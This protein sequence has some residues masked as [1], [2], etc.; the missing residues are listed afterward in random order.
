MFR[1][2]FIWFARSSTAWSR[3][4]W[5]G[6]DRSGLSPRELVERERS[7]VAPLLHLGELVLERF[8]VHD[9]GAVLAGPLPRR[10]VGVLVVVPESLAVLGLRLRPEVAAAGLAPV[11]RVDAHQLAELEEV[12]DPAGPLQGLVHAV[13]AAEDLD[14]APEVLAERPDQVDGLAQAVSG[15]LHAAVLP[16]DV[17]ELAV[18]GVDAAGAVGAKELL[19]LLRDR[20]L[21]LDHGR[22]VLGHLVER[23]LGQ[24]V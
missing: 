21:R 16:H 12:G 11:E 4:W 22:V 1:V 19:D 20:L 6:A 13:G 9:R 5:T 23:A 8:L 14:V 15:A 10:H 3:W 17:A 2:T 18:V 24:V 7:L